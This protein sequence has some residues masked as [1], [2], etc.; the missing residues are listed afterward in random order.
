L[1]RDLGGLLRLADGASVSEPAEGSLLA[2]GSAL[3]GACFELWLRTPASEATHAADGTEQHGTE[4]HGSGQ[5]S[6]T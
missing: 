2:E 4:Q 5:Q 1:A 3:G 6:V